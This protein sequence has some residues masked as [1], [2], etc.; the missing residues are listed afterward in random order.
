MTF[1]LDT[2]RVSAIIAQCA[3]THVVPRFRALAAHD[4]KTKTSAD[5]LVTQADLE[6][7]KALEAA[8]LSAFPGTRFLGEEGVA[9]GTVTLD[10]LADPDAGVWVVDPIDGTWN[11]VHGDEK[12][13]TLVAFVKGGRTLAGW[14]YDI[15][16]RAMTLAQ[17]GRGVF[18]DGARFG[19]SKTTTAA[20]ALGAVNPNYFPPD[21]A[22]PL[23][24]A[25][26]AAGKRVVLRCAAHEYL[27]F[28]EGRIDFSLHHRANPWDHLAGALA[29]TE[30]GG[31][32]RTWSGAPYVPSAPE[33]LL[34]A[35]NAP[36]WEDVQQNILWK[37]TRE[38]QGE[39]SG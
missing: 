17:A 33:H 36:L 18:R 26:N 7:E 12:F 37:I 29:V 13:G 10:L 16:R 6:M 25:L 3:Q 2:D 15:P 14:I 34:I 21:I 4:V 28:I 32:V 9:A 24:S 38:P 11:F 39:F 23:D 35:S 1:P 20:Q 30:L 27:D 5:D 22:Q 8:L 19:L 31:I